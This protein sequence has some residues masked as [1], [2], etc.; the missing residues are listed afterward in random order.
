MTFLFDAE[1]II[2][3]EQVR[4]LKFGNVYEFFTPQGK[5]LGEAR[6]EGISFL[7]KFFRMTKYKNMLPFTVSLYDAGGTKLVT[8]RRPFTFFMSHVAVLD[9]SGKT[10]GTYRQKFRLSK[11]KLL[12]L[13]PGGAQL[14]TMEGSFAGWHFAIMSGGGKKLVDISKKWAGAARELFTTADTYAVRIEAAIPEE[15]RR[16]LIPVACVIDLV[17]RDRT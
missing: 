17:F 3:K 4:V 15:H 8:L 6:E 1:E 9:A 2:V 16:L 12:V 7:Q 10:L 13:D 11:P 14:A 5:K